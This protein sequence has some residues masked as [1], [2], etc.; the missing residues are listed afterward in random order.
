MHM[1]A[2]TS[3]CELQ[4]NLVPDEKSLRIE[5]GFSCHV[6]GA[7]NLTFQDFDYLCNMALSTIIRNRIKK[8]PEGK[9]FG[10]A[11][12]NMAKESYA[13]A[14]K[15]LERLQ[16]EGLLKKVVSKG[17][18]Y[19]PQQTVFGELEPDESELLRPCLFENGKCVA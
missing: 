12:L 13:A 16:K 14:A 18:F 7:I 15:V 9:T 2:P 6:Y 17:M 4:P 3:I 10:Y 19:K 1:P 8:F 5:L 11:D